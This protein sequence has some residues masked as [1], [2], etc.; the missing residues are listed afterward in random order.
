[1]LAIF[2]LWIAMLRDWNKKEVDIFSPVAEAILDPISSMNL[3]LWKLIYMFNIQGKISFLYKFH[4][5]LQCCCCKAGLSSAWT[6]APTLYPGQLRLHRYDW[7]GW[8]DWV[9]LTNGHVRLIRGGVSLALGCQFLLLPFQPF[10][11]WLAL[12]DCSC[13]I[14]CDA[15][16]L[17]WC[18]V[19]D[20]LVMIC[21][22]EHGPDIL[23]LYYSE[24][25]T[26]FI[27]WSIARHPGRHRIWSI[28]KFCYQAVQFFSSS[29][30]LVRL[31]FRFF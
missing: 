7:W 16:W 12:G 25:L 21:G 23:G 5:N 18:I 29:L 2:P 11:G 10:D 14:P 1:M 26:P 13:A 15:P 24:D 19:L 20:K 31:F 4:L 6:W 8:C 9:V 17:K 28:S 30:I 3:R 22:Y 27:R